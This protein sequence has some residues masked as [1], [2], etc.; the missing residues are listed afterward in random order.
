MRLASQTGS[1]ASGSGCRGPYEVRTEN[2]DSLDRGALLL[3]VA[4]SETTH[5]PLAALVHE[6][7]ARKLWVD[8]RLRAVSTALLG[9]GHNTGPSDS[10]ARAY[11]QQPLS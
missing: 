9:V 3:S 10:T 6:L 7:V 1:P 11:V 5:S 2:P 8:C 4:R